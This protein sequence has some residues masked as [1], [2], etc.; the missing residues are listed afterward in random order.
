MSPAKKH[1]IS[2][3]EIMVLLKATVAFLLFNWITDFLYI[4]SI[5]ITKKMA[6]KKHSLLCKRTL[7]FNSILLQ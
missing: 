6:S 7:A 3:R 2:K 4:Y 1:I 5:Y